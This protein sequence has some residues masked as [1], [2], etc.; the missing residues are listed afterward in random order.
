MHLSTSYVIVSPTLGVLL[1]ERNKEKMVCKNMFVLRLLLRLPNQDATV[2]SDEV[3]DVI[4]DLEFVE[5]E[6]LHGK[7][8]ARHITSTLQ[9]MSLI[10]QRSRGQ[11]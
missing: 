5:H 3:S 7:T 1:K 4:N 10:C 11:T 9:N 6:C 2:S 8:M